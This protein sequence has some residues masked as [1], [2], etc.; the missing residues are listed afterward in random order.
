L[1]AVFFV[2]ELNFVVRSH[3]GIDKMMEMGLG[4]QVQGVLG[5]AFQ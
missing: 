3:P 5:V 4:F 1:G 2:Q